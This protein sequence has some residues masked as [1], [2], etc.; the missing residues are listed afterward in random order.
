MEGPTLVSVDSSSIA[1]VG[2][3]ATRRRLYIDFVGGHTYTY[4]DVPPE[5]HA[6]LLRANSKGGYFNREIRNAYAYTRLDPRDAR[7]LPR[8]R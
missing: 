6:A 1:A 5:T 4:H 3:D 7:Q 8:R 2:Y